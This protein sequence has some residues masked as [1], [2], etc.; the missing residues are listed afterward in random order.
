MDEIMIE[1]FNFVLLTT[2]ENFLKWVASELP[3]KSFALWGWDENSSEEF[4]VGDISMDGT[5]YPPDFEESEKYLHHLYQID[6]ELIDN[7]NKSVNIRKAVTF[8]VREIR[9]GKIQAICLS[10]DNPYILDALH[11]MKDEILLIFD[12][13]KNISDVGTY[14]TQRNNLKNSKN[15]ESP[16]MMVDDIGYD[17]KLVELLSNGASAQEIAKR[18]GVEPKTVFNREAELRSRYGV[19]IVPYRQ[20]WRNR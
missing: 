13:D 14:Q 5:Y 8:E 17:R 12:V 16:W 3:K 4:Q 20:K 1:I 2:S 9:E 6:V 18:V 7:E 10:N 15:Q 19:E 11:R